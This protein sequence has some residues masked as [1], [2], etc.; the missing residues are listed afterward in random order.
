MREEGLPS[1]DNYKIEPVPCISKIGVAM[2]DESHCNDLHDELEGED[3]CEE[4]AAI[5]DEVV[6]GWWGVVVIGLVIIEHEDNSVAENEEEYGII[7]P[8]P[9]DEPDKTSSE[10]AVIPDAA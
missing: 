6:I 7:E 2:E 8:A 3:A 4:E 10:F 5:E 9:G 1:D